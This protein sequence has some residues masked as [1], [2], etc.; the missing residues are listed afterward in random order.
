MSSVL[1]CHGNS[2][3]RGAFSLLDEV[4]SYPAQLTR[5]L[6]SFEPGEWVVHN[7]GTDGLRLP[8]MLTEFNTVVNVHAGAGANIVIMQELGNTLQTP[9]TAQQVIDDALAYCN[10]A[11]LAGWTVYMCT[12]TPRATWGSHQATLDTIN[13][14]VRAN[15]QDFGSRLIDLAVVQELT[16]P[17]NLTYY[18]G[19][20]THLKNSGFTAMA[21]A[22]L[23]VVIPGAKA[24]H[25]E[26]LLDPQRF[27]SSLMNGLITATEVEITRIP[28][29]PLHFEY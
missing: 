24:Q 22:A 25:A 21:L 11:Q 3:T 2:L 19:D 28:G 1:V 18:D 23:D 6:A 15:F 13:A 20:G 10:A 16:D 5:L 27:M 7:E 17:T 29:G 12:A 9:K 26:D 14:Y 4:Y 8:A